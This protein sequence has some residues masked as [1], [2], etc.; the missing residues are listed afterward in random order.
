MHLD[1]ARPLLA[2]VLGEHCAL[3]DSFAQRPVISCH[4]GYDLCYYI[5]KR[6]RRDKFLHFFL[7]NGLD[8]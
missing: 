3:K 4:S 7:S 1:A 8:H 6:G 5:L 2:N